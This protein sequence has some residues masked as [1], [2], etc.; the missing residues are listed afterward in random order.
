MA[1]DY[2]KMLDRLYLSLPKHTLSRERFKM[3]AIES[4]TQGNKTVVKNFSTIARTIKRDEKHLFK[5]ITKEIATAASIEEGRLVL[6]G[7]FTE[8]QLG[9]L[10]QAYLKQFVLCRECGKPDTKFIEHQGVKMLKCEACGAMAPVKVI[11]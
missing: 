1:M 9:Q 8:E 4:F 3:P 5:F 6:N 10:L 2:E 11:R 7:R